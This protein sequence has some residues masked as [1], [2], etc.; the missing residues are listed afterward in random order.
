M[1]RGDW[2][3]FENAVSSWRREQSCV[4]GNFATSPTEMFYKISCSVTMPPIC[5]APILRL[6]L[7]IHIARGDL[8]GSSLT[9]TE[10]HDIILPRINELWAQAGICFAI[11]DVVDHRWA[12]NVNSIPLVT[13]KDRIWGLCR[14]PATGKMAG[15]AERREI[16]LDH[17][18]G[19]GH[20]TPNTYDIWVFDF[21]GQQSQGCCISRQSRTIICG[22][23]STKGYAE[24]TTRP[25][26]CLGKTLAHELGH[27]VGLDHPMGTKFSDGTSCTLTSQRNNLMT[28][29]SDVRGGGG[30]LLEVWQI[31]SARDDA[32]NFLSK[33]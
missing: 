2:T 17:L 13:L 9:A 7:R 5:M 12:D 25:L 30:I 32:A 4:V 31:L 14:D 26:D 10:C 1:E 23:R 19:N 22:S 28:G 27:A 6:P 33:N 24:P 21:V 11:V 16:F 15:K 8:L 29:G 18:I 3:E 20:E